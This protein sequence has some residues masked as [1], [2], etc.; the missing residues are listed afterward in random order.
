MVSKFGVKKLVSNIFFLFS[1]YRLILIEIGKGNSIID[2]G[3]Q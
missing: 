2:S 3:L 1:I